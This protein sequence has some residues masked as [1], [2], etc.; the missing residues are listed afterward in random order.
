MRRPLR[1]G[2]VVINCAD[3]ELITRFWCQALGLRQGPATEDGMFRVLGGADVNVSLQVA[4]SPISALEF[5]P[6]D[7]H[8]P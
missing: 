3:L 8:L 1:L 4:K 7:G 5:S 6:V 2:S